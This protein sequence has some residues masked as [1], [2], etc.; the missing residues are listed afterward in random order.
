MFCLENGPAG[1]NERL[2]ALGQ[3]GSLSPES[4]P[5]IVENGKRESIYAAGTMTRRAPVVRPWVLR[6][7]ALP[8]AVIYGA[9]LILVMF[10]LPEGLADLGRRLSV[11]LRRRKK[12]A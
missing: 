10:F 9:L 12:N 4:I 8:P 6:R 7:K 3:V 1:P 5:H 2:A 11:L